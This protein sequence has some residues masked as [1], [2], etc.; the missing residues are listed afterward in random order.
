MAAGNQRATTAATAPTRAAPATAGQR[1]KRSSAATRPR[2]KVTPTSPAAIPSA[3][4]SGW[5][6]SDGVGATGSGNIGPACTIRATIRCEASAAHSAVPVPRTVGVMRSSSSTKTNPA[7][8]AVNAA[9]KPAPAPAAWSRRRLHSS[10]RSPTAVAS[11]APMCT[12]GPSRPSDS[13]DAS[14]SAPAKNLTG[15]TRRQRMWPP[16]SSSSS[17]AGIP[18]PAASGAMRPVSQRASAAPAAKSAAS[19]T[20]PSAV[21][22]SLSTRR[23]RHGVT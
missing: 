22:P 3:T 23:V 2:L 5:S 1:S 4:K 21:S 7:N 14:A 15:R 16:R 8:G 10:Y 17:T 13:P 18:L 6:S 12:V 20:R 11:A 19:A 9:V